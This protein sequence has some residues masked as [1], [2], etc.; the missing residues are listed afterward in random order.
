MKLS[1]HFDLEEFTRRKLPRASASTT[2]HRSA[3]SPTCPGSP[4]RWR[5]S[6]M[7]VAAGR[8]PSAAATDVRRS[9]SALG[10]E[11]S[12]HMDGR[13]ADIHVRGMSPEALRRQSSMPTLSWI[14]SS[15]RV[16]GFTSASQSPDP[17]R[18]VTS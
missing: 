13:A 11:E 16:H 3:S 7:R 6:A 2:R 14:N 17:R 4:L 10:G 15:T 8:S 1:E 18:A 5:P 12:A 9:I